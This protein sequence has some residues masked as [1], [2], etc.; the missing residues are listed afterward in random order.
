VGGG[1]GSSPPSPGHPLADALGQDRRASACPVG[2]SD[3]RWR[4]ASHYSRTTQG[5]LLGIV[6]VALSSAELRRLADLSAT[7][8][9]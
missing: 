1:Y 2:A 9:R 6:K 4:A 8:T 7:V 3:R 5:H